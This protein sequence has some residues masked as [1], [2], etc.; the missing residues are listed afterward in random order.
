MQTSDRVYDTGTE[1][2][3][4][5]H[6]ADGI[7]VVRRPP[8]DSSGRDRCRRPCRMRRACRSRRLANTRFEVR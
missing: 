7:D 1:P 6:R 2:E 3:R 5:R 8:S 4:H